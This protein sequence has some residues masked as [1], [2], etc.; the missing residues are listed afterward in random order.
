MKFVLKYN[1]REI[2]NIKKADGTTSKWDR[3]SYVLIW[4]DNDDKKITS[5]CWHGNDAQDRMT[6][7]LQQIKTAMP[8]MIL[9]NETG[10]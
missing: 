6:R 2:C 3:S 9:E 10:A 5:W 8:D 7:K 1:K 4:L